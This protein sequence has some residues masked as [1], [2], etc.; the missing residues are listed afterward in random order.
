MG[1]RGG[2]SG[3]SREQQLST[4]IKKISDKIKKLQDESMQV[5]NSRENSWDP[6]P[7]RYHELSREVRSLMNKRSDLQYKREEERRKNEPVTPRTFVNSFGEATKREITSAS[8]ERAQ[9]RLDKQI[10]SRFKGR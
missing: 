7:Q 5:L 1:G 10:W 8:Y 6:Y 3:L 9:R 2:N 4:K